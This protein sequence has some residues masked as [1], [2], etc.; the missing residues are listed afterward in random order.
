MYYEKDIYFMIYSGL[1]LLAFLF[2]PVKMMFFSS[3]KTLIP[4]YD[5]IDI[6]EKYTLFGTALLIRHKESGRI[7]KQGFILPKETGQTARVIRLLESEGL[8]CKF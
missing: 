4:R 3:G 6:Q 7:K 1:L 2:I 5:I 8:I